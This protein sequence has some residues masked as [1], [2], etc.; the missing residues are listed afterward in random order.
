MASAIEAIFASVNPDVVKGDSL[1]EQVV[2]ALEEARRLRS[3]SIALQ[4]AVYKG[5]TGLFESLAKA[6]AGA[7]AAAGDGAIPALREHLFRA[8]AGSEAN[9]LLRAGAITAVVA[10]SK[11]LAAELRPAILDLA[12]EDPS[13]MVRG[14][15]SSAAGASTS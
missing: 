7:D 13:T 12:K 14:R 3:P 10:F 4:R 9:R 15:L 11:A 5:I 8:D 6:N 2:A 1:R